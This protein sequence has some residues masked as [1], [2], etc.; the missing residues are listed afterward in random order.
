MSRQDITDKG[1][2]QPKSE[3]FG[4]KYRVN[5]E[6]SKLLQE[7]VF[8]DGGGWRTGSTKALHEKEPY[9]YVGDDGEMFFG[10]DDSSFELK[11]L[12]EKQPPQPIKVEPTKKEFIVGKYYKCVDDGKCFVHNGLTKDKWFQLTHISSTGGLEVVT[13]VGKHYDPKRFDINS[14]SDYDPNTAHG[15]F[16]EDLKVAFPPFDKVVDTDVK[17]IKLDDIVQVTI[18]R[19]TDTNNFMSSFLT[20]KEEIDMSNQRKVVEVQLFDDAK[21]LPVQDS[22]VAKFEN[23]LTEDD[24]DTTIREVIMNNDLKATLKAH[25]AKRAKVTNLDILERTGNSVPLQPILLKDLRWKVI[26]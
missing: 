10:N 6:T 21:G 7:A 14:E 20:T 4:F 22:L 12:P 25:N 15:K 23:V 8:K 16:V 5:P 19:S 24:N 3:W 1:G 2:T 11:E 17:E 18:V 9:L 26:G 13:D